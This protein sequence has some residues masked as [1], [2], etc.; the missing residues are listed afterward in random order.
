MKVC[1][2]WASKDK[3]GSRHTEKGEGVMGGNSRGKGRAGKPQI[4]RPGESREPAA[5]TAA[6]LLA[7]TSRS[8]PSSGSS[9]H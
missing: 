8:C 4:G 3:V 6:V 2:R 7:A 5:H 1:L 9:V